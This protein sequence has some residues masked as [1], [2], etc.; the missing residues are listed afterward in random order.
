MTVTRTVDSDQLAG[1]EILVIGTVDMTRAGALFANAPVRFNDGR[2]QVTERSFVRR[3]FDTVS[4]Y[5]RDPV[6]TVNGFLYLGYRL[7]VLH[8]YALTSGLGLDVQADFGDPG[9]DR[10]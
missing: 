3:A 7:E 6:S 5:E 4:P 1:K 8:A 2:F 9:V 10:A